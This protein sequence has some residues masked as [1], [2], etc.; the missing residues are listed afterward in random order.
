VTSESVGRPLRIVLVISRYPPH[1]V[2]GYEL[3]CR[4]VA[5]GLAR[6]GNSVTVLT[7]SVGARGTQIDDGVSV[8][9]ELHLFPD[10]VRGR[11]E[12]WAFARA[13]SKD[14]ARLRRESA[15]ADVVC[16]WHQMG[17]SSALLAVPLSCG[18]LCDVSSDWLLEAAT[19]GGNWFRIWEKRPAS[20][21]KRAAKAALRP[22]VGALLAV[23]TKR[24]AFP[25]GSCYFTSEQHRKRYLAAGVRVADAAL[26]RSGVDLERFRFVPTRPSGGPT[27]LFL[28]RVKR[29]K[30]LH[31]IVLAMRDL[32]KD[33]RLLAVGPIE[34]ESYVAEIAEMARAVGVF[35]RVSFRA[36]V[37]H[38][39]TPAVLADAHVL[40]AS[41]E[42]PEAFSRLVLE[43]FAVGTP[44]VGT[45]IGG[46]GE[47]LVDGET[48][49]A[50]PP[51][52]SNALAAA[53][54]R[55]FGDDA[56]RAR[57][58]ANARRLVEQRYSLDGTVA[59]IEELLADAARKARA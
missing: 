31:T 22:C 27:I 16:F 35:D 13:T 52:D 55:L 32:P 26:I 34:D 6:R 58:V 29:R 46:T 44:V 40:V 23:P 8:V 57:V 37:P 1:H 3:R 12:T 21:V 33:A 7:S 18:V 5:R 14:C 4:D 28:S 45:T 53:L 2:G 51:G 43:A 38:S 56:L 19:T 41:S 54:A 9:R 36:A 11:A 20:L 25:P 15:G 30:G 39:E 42:E 24:P 47:V 48:G 50:Y 17:L 10:G 49:L 59:R